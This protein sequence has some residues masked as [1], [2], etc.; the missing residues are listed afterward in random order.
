[1]RDEWFGD[2]RDLL[3]WTI[4]IEIARVYQCSRILQVLYRRPTNWGQIEFDGN[5]I[6]IPIDVIRH[7]RDCTSIHQLQ[8]EPSIDVIV[9]EFNDHGQYLESIL[10]F[11][12]A[13][14][15]GRGI[16]FL[17]PDTGLQP[18]NGTC[19]PEHVR[20]T[21]VPKIWNH[22]RSGDV[23]AL[24]Q[25]ANRNKGWREEKRKQF[26]RELGFA[27]PNYGRVKV[28]FALKQPKGTGRL[29]VDVAFFFAQ[30]E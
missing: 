10:A 7:F 6:E 21:D 17:D 8:C 23:L 28:A 18:E 27:E 3:K 4:L 2:N 9:E 26:A 13:W 14:R 25:H 30:K 12:G 24:Y 15:N 19:K 22:L 29:P 11:I 5:R 16:A 1:M 20:S